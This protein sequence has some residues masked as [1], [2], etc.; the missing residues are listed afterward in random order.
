M[1][2]A[3]TLE[4]G[5]GSIVLSNKNSTHILKPCPP[6]YPNLP[7]N[8]HLSQLIM[9]Q[10]G[11]VV[12]DCGVLKFADNSIAY[13][14]KRYDRLT[15]GSKIHQE[16]LLAALGIANS[17]QDV[18]YVGSYELAANVMREIGGI[19][20][21]AEFINRVIA[22]YIIGNGDYHLKN[23]SLVYPKDSGVTISPVYDFVNT[24]IYDDKVTLCLDLLTNEPDV[25]E[26][27][28]FYCLRKANFVELGGRVGVPEKAIQGF[29]TSIF[30][31]L[32]KML[33]LID[34]SALSSEQKTQYKTLFTQRIELLA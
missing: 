4:G 20:L 23:I 18:K 14:I 1:G 2:I 7:I 28:D 8:E 29:I 33:F 12:P 11:F 9:R 24:Y 3:T 34:A 25:K 26:F 17:N 31:N 5:K 22:A 16:D 19:Q 30:K 15:D 32:E 13:F 6:G 21:A 10:L 27:D